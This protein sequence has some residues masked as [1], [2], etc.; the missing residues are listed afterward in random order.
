MG[1]LDETDPFRF[2]VIQEVAR[3]AEKMLEQRDKNLARLIRN[4]MSEMLG[5]MFK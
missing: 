1:L 2:L 5:K 4:D 3:L